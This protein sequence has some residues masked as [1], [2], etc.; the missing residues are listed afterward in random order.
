MNVKEAFVALKTDSCGSQKFSILCYLQ[1][2]EVALYNA[3]GIQIYGKLVNRPE[4]KQVQT[5]LCSGAT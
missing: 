1:G 5:L 2:A 3:R 4:V